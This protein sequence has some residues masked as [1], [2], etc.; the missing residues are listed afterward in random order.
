VKRTL[1]LIVAVATFAPPAAASPVELTVTPT[2]G[3]DAPAGPGWFSY[4]L[5]LRGTESGVQRGTVEVTDG[6]GGTSRAPF[7]VA[8]GD[9]VT[10]EL[11]AHD[12]YGKGL[13]AL[14][15]DTDGAVVARAPVSAARSR[16]PFLFD[17]AT[18]SRLPAALRDARVAVHTGAPSWAPSE[19]LTLSVQGVNTDPKSGELLLSR[20]AAGYSSATVT[21][22][23]SEALVSLGDSEM[24]AL[25]EWVCSGGTLA[26][27][28]GR[29]EDLA[30]P[31]L[32]ALV[33]PRVTLDEKGSAGSHTDF[34]VV[35]PA[36]SPTTTGPGGPPTTGPSLTTQRI[37]PSTDVATRLVGFHGERL[38]ETRWGASARHGLGDVHLL[39]FDPNAPDFVDDAWVRASVVELVR[40]AWDQQADTA[41]VGGRTGFDGTR[42]DPARKFL[43]PNEAH[44]WTVGF[45]AIVLLGYSLIAGP[46]VFRRAAKKN[47]PLR[48][49]R[50]LPLWS[51]G[52]LV[53][54]V[55]IGLFA[56]GGRARARRL[57]VVECRAGT[58]HCAAMRLRAFFAS[59]AAALHVHS[60]GV[61]DLLDVASDERTITRALVQD[62]EGAHLQELRGRPWETV[63]VREDG[64]VDLGGKVSFRSTGADVEIV[65][66]LARDLVAVVAHA[67][68]GDLRF[69][70]RIPKGT[71]A[72]IGAGEALG[73]PVVLTTPVLP[74]KG[75]SGT[76]HRLEAY[77]FSSKADLASHE[78]GAAWT[79]LETLAQEDAD[80]W[81]DDAP[82]LVGE[83][84][85]GDGVTR[86]SGLAVDKN[87]WLIR[88]VGEGALP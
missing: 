48:V 65:N 75:P 26:V 24:R 38:Q 27:V 12:V 58:E 2:L 14:A 53:L 34:D 25:D 30:H 13:E 8:G 52:T 74:V 19:G 59:S 10:V 68:G 67:P 21:L 7:A 49:L 43:D 86:D 80:F 5:H 83:L 23:R 87:H 57:A 32:V 70:R 31:R 47:D 1:L 15:R 60:N 73:T 50:E 4:L 46:V 45:S 16:Q 44:Q 62:G 18:P 36:G 76:T 54:I 61:T 88:V 9:Q 85:G 33:G 64:F 35:V 6:S 77:R 42:L 63:L 69:F 72:R 11:F 40:R 71:S 37:P 28:V 81:P 66:G 84:E 39:A 82:T 79:A 3:A 56:R 41:F 17:L 78:S 55:A 22:A 20:R 51:L 29:P